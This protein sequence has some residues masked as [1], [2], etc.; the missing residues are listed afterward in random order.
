MCSISITFRGLHRTFAPPSKDGGRPPVDRRGSDPVLGTAGC[1]FRGQ[2]VAGRHGFPEDFSG[3]IYV[4]YLIICMYIYIYMYTYIYICIYIY[5]LYWSIFTT[6]DPVSVC[7]KPLLF[8]IFS[9]FLLWHIRISCE[10]IHL[11]SKSRKRK[12]GGQIHRWQLEL[13]GGFSRFR[14]TS[15][16]DVFDIQISVSCKVSLG[17]I[18]GE[19]S[20]LFW[21]E[22]WPSYI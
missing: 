20:Q 15:S 7:K 17:Q 12:S 6:D 10:F 4:W 13:I 22:S 5:T 21:V 14:T 1:A 19:I 9:M 11:S 3:V 16:L 18:L 8:S 2:S